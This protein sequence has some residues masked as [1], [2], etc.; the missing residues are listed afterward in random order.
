MKQLIA[1]TF[2][3]LLIFSTSMAQPNA[4]KYLPTIAGI[5]GKVIDKKTQEPL[6]YVTVTIENENGEI[7][8][9][10]ITDD[11]GFFTISSIPVGT[12]NVK[13]QYIGFIS[14]SKELTIEKNNESIDLGIISLEE[15]IASLDEVVVVAEQSTIVQKI[16]RR[17]INVGKDLTTAGATAGEIMN[18]IPSINV[19]QDG[20]IALR[21]NQNVKIL[22]DGKPTNIDAAQLLR[23]IPSSS[24]KQI[25][26][27]T[28]P[29]AKYNPEGMSGIIN[30][31]LHKN[32]NDG[33]N[34]DVSLNLTNG[35]YARFNSSINL[36]YRTGKLNFYGNYGAYAGKNPN[37]GELEMEDNPFTDVFDP[38]EQNFDLLS[39]SKSH[40]FKFGVDYYIDDK[41]SLSV[42]TTQNLYNYKMNAINETYYDG[43]AAASQTSFSKSGNANAAYNL[44]YKHKINEDGHE[45][46]LEADYNDFEGDSDSDYFFSNSP[47]PNYIESY[48]NN[49]ENTTI[50]LDY[51]NPLTENIKLEVGLEARIQ[52]TKNDYDTSTD[53]ISNSDFFYNRDIY[54]A[55]ATFGQ[56]IDKWSYQVGVRAET[57]NVEAGFSNENTPEIPFKD[58]LFTLYPS[59]F[60]SYALNDKNSMQLSYSRRVDRPGLNQINPI[61]EF[62]TP[63]LTSVGNQNLKPQFTN[64]IELNYSKQLNKGNITAGVFYRIIQ[65]EINRTILIDELDPS[66]LIQTYDNFDGNKAYGL[67]VSGA[68]RPTAWWSFNTSFDLYS[69]NLNGLV[70]FEKVEIENTGYTFRI[71]NNIKATKD[72]TFQLFGMYR[73]SGSSLQFDFTDF[74]FI[75]TGVRYNVMQGNATIS[76]NVNDVFNTQKAK[77]E[78]TRPYPMRGEFNWD[79]Q[80]WQV[81]LSYR[82]GGVNNRA[83][84]RKQR[85]KGETQGGGGIF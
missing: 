84:S 79:S 46:Q 56:K 43:L 25:E 58:D 3:F 32:T 72:L 51:T 5:S 39:T 49:R 21:G 29:S 52:N 69:Q 74:Y 41:N 71:N 16:D 75:N 64:S 30:I 6:P 38:S 50:N 47:M 14:Y 7:L 65:D 20:N 11:N 80:T 81:G 82:F 44:A 70:A 68:Y 83:L 9:G 10:G 66:K 60:V 19:D 61:R 24:I 2:T 67:E 8:T 4:E 36:N 57:F 55:Y 54:S 59:A 13:I 22:I 73:S 15:D 27:I 35:E 62:S 34:G 40:L 45:I 33:F 1:I 85:D 26:L 76:F 53:L 37:K 63:T 28:N 42:Y 77:F 31:I 17:V 48:N 23:Q 12:V 18:N 78:T